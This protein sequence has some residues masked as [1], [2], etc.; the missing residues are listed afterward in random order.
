MRPDL[1]VREARARELMDDPAADERMLERTYALFPA[2]N[3]V[4][5]GWRGVYRREIRPLAGR[6]TLRVLDV[7]TGGGDVARALARRLQRDGCDARV[8]GLD[9]DARAIRWASTQ[10][11]SSPVRWVRA[12]TSDLVRE[13]A[14]FDV[15][16]SNHVLHHLSSG[17]L[18]TVL[19][20]SLRLT[21]PGGVVL[22]SDIARSRAAYALFAAATWPFART[23][24]AG[25]FIRPDGLTSIRRAYTAG[26][27]AAAAGEG[28]R[29][30][31]RMPF[32]LLLTAR[33]AEAPRT[34]SARREDGDA[35]G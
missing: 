28:W 20:D 6:G 15:V 19:D 35:H 32:R 31:S 25:S 33:R 27:L 22:H 1:S 12:S 29:V 7:G 8:T 17:E 13:G 10:Q 26:E 18:R 11:A 23:L 4:V 2:V 24:L 21:A 9:V 3:A 34:G 14:V 16:L 30:E 5:S